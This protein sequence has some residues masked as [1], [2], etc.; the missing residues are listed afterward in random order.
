[1]Q[2]AIKIKKKNVYRKYM[3]MLKARWSQNRPTG[4]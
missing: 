3:D 1:M 2:K 4:D